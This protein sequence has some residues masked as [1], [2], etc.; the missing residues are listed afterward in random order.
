MR[1]VR[2]RVSR[3][4]GS[5]LP[6]IPLSASDGGMAEVVTKNLMW[7][8]RMGKK[9]CEAAG[10][11]RGVGHRKQRLAIE[12]LSHSAQLHR[13]VCYSCCLPLFLGRGQGFASPFHTNQSTILQLQGKGEAR[14]CCVDPSHSMVFSVFILTISGPAQQQFHTVPKSLRHKGQS[15]VVSSQDSFAY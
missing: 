6:F 14:G 9:G 5:A 7:I 1:L 8:P 4:S 13:R 2:I 12:K 10:Q 11:E 3:F 15:T